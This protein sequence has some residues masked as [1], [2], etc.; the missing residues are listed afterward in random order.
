MLSVAAGWLALDA[1]RTADAH[2][3]YTKALASARQADDPGLE[4]HAFA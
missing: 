4:A 1:G 2:F 3:L